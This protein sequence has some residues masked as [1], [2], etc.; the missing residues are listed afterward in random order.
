MQKETESKNA[1]FQGRY[2]T[3]HTQAKKQ[4]DEKE[5]QRAMAVSISKEATGILKSF[6]SAYTEANMILSGMQSNLQS[7]KKLQDRLIR[8]MSAFFDTTTSAYMVCPIPTRSGDLVPFR[9]IVTEWIN[10][11]LDFNGEIHATFRCSITNGDNSIASAEQVSL[12]RR[13]AKDLG[14]SL[15]SPITVSI[16]QND[17]PFTQLPFYEQL[18]VASCLC[19]LYRERNQ[20]PEETVL[21]YKGQRFIRLKISKGGNPQASK[22]KVC[23]EFGAKS[24]G[25]GQVALQAHQIQLT[26]DHTIFSEFTFQSRN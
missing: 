18:R 10:N 20:E 4:I 6:V 1:E 5:A 17:E 13:L 7:Q 25:A 9:T 21:L 26:A 15:K 16:Q 19:K 14:I 2:S 22:F 24:T 3:M 12:I 8:G 11:P 23:C